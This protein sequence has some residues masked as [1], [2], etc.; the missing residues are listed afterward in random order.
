MQTRKR[1]GGQIVHYKTNRWHHRWKHL[2][3]HHMDCGP[4]CFYVLKYADYDTSIEMARRTQEGINE[5]LILQLINEAY[6][7]GHEW[8]VISQ[9]GYSHEYRNE[10]FIDRDGEEDHDVTHYFINTYL[11]PNEAT[12]ASIR[13]GKKLHFFVVLREEDGLFAIDAQEGSIYPLQEFMEYY[14]KEFG[15]SDLKI[16]DYRLHSREPHK[17]TM[18]M[19]KRY[20]PFKGEIKKAEKKAE[21]RRRQS[22]KASMKQANRESRTILFSKSKSRSRSRKSKSK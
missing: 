9:L 19:I 4:N 20:F 14:A 21:S 12:L 18:N 6:G 5:Y 1:L 16:V 7:H 8:R 22:E 17:V 13:F 3:M 2:R 15:S 10:K 11:E